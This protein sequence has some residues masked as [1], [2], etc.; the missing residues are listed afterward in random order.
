M[1]HEILT[2]MTAYLSDVLRALAEF[3][4][5]LLIALSMLLLGFLTAIVLRA[6]TRLVLRWLHFNTLMERTGARQFIQRA[7]LGEPDELAGGLVFWL[8]WIVLLLLA[9]RTLGVMAVDMLAQDFVRYLP[10]LV[11]AV[12]V[13][14]L[15]VFFSTLAWRASL[16]AAVNARVPAAKL[17]GALVRWVT[18]VAAVAMALE[19]LEIGRQVILTAFAIS[20]GAIMLALALA[21]GLGGRHL[22]RRYLERRFHGYDPEQEPPKRDQGPSH[23]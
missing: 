19:Q 3:L 12:V 2:A 11:S 15:G 6:V 8:T 22:A 9:L 20:F 1:T 7:Q 13:I 16:L 17:V 4:P 21:F 10:K 5:R 23:L 18:I 14:V